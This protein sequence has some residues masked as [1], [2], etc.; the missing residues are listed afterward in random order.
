MTS[1]W[2]LLRDRFWQIALLVLILRAV[3]GPA[4]LLA[5]GVVAIYGL[6][7]RRQAVEAILLCWY[8][9]LANSAIF[10]AIPNASLARYGVIFLIA[11]AMVLRSAGRPLSHGVV[12]TLVLGFYI[13]L[14]SALFSVV[15][16]ISFL[17]G[18]IWTLA[19]VTVLLAFTSMQQNEMRRA[20]Q[21]IYG[22]LALVLA[23]SVPVYFLQ[24]GGSM[25]GYSYLRGLLGH[26]QAIGVVGAMVGAW[27]FAR[28]VDHSRLAILDVMIFALC[29]YVV[30]LSGARTALLSI[31]F[32]MFVT[33]FL[34]IAKGKRPLKRLLSHLRNPLV[35][36][37]VGVI[38]VGGILFAGPLFTSVM[39][40]LQKNS[41]SASIAEAYGESR[42]ALIDEMLDNIREDPLTGIGFGI[43]SDP[44]NMVVETVSGIPISA[45]V[46]K[47]VT[48]IAVW[49]ELGL[50]GLFLVIYWA[51]VIFSNAARAAL[52]QFALLLSIFVLNL[53]EATLFSAG[54]MGLLQILFIGFASYRMRK[55]RQ[56]LS[57]RSAFRSQTAYVSR[58]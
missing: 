26:S 57:P 38:A 32:C 40:T 25:F 51:T 16:T 37:G 50:L 19:T 28:L 29:F 53:G 23:L 5:Y 35:A 14:H 31:P 42:G 18:A 24:P 30:M 22:F 44:E 27:A 39:E 46:E 34:A 21:H 6:G 43:A 13:L 33:S 45:V 12:A 47:G 7:G 41:E 1:F 10:G 2:L 17:K 20:E 58:R 54:G 3:G 36:L 56:R 9:T 15:G 11:G 48:H 52:G 4:G 49:E 55:Q 8:I